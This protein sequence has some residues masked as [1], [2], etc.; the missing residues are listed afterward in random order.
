MVKDSVGGK[1][2]GQ[3]C[4]RCLPDIA[5]RV[6][7]A[8]RS[9][10]F[11]QNAEKRKS[12]NYHAQPTEQTDL[13]NDP[14]GLRFKTAQVTNSTLLGHASGD[15]SRAQ[16]SPERR[17]GGGPWDVAQDSPGALFEGVGILVSSHDSVDDVRW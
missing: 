6:R 16:S 1:E 4:Q 15:L 11:P 12:K 17:H 10:R 8:C 2:Y 9:D 13:I 3:G 5:E 14:A 7:S